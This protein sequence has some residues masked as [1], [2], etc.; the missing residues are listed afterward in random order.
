MV[1]ESKRTALGLAAEEVIPCSFYTRSVALHN[2]QQFAERTSIVTVI[3]SDP[4]IRTQPELC[5]DSTLFY[6]DM[7]RLAR[8]PFVG[9]E[10]EPETTF[11]KDGWFLAAPTCFEAR[12]N[13]LLL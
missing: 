9:I 12:A 11:E 2:L 1:S 5:F 10:E 3:V 7:D 4:N 8:C 6:V 13:S